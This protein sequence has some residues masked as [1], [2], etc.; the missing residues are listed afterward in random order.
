VASKMVEE[1]GRV[2]SA[3]RELRGFWDEKQNNMRQ[4]II[5]MFKTINNSSNL[6]SLLIVLK[7]ISNNFG[8]KLL[9]MKI[10][11]ATVQN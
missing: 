5:Y 7:L 6:E 2:E 9:L 4:T 10:L 1:V 3:R 11:S 8:L